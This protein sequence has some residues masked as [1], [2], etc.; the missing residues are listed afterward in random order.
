[1]RTLRDEQKAASPEEDG[2]QAYFKQVK[3]IPLL[4]FEEELALSKRIQ[5]GDTQARQTLVEANLRL[6]VKIAQ[7]YS[8]AGDV[9]IMD[10]IQEGNLGLI[11]AAE[12]YSYE[13]NFRFATYANWW[14]RQ[15]ISRFLT[16]KRR[17]IRLPHRKEATLRRIR[18]AYQILSQ[19]LMRQPKSEDIAAELGIP[20]EDVEFILQM[21]NRL[22]S[23]DTEEDDSASL[24]LEMYVD[25]TYSPEREFIKK[26]ILDDT[27]RML[28]R[29]NDQE[30]QVLLYRYQLKGG[31]KYT[32]RTIGAKLGIAAETVRQIELRALKTIR[33][34]AKEFQDSLYGTAM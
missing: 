26:S 6:V 7:T 14:I 4:T 8:P 21:T 19:T 13:K 34:H 12:K 31:K 30:K 33:I 1:M 20:V 16:N 2:L 3:R 29:L 25:Y 32:L 9:P 17:V 24:V 22:V 5:Q 27:L 11:H 10:L 23:L 15:F 18:K 28:N